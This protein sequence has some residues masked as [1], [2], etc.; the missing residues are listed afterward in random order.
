V[1]S[2]NE[3]GPSLIYASIPGPKLIENAKNLKVGDY[4]EGFVGAEG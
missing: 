3:N 4:V 1:S 2:R